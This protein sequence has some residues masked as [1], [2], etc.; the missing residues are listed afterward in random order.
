MLPVHP[1]L[2]LEASRTRAKSAIAREAAE[3][4]D[5]DESTSGQGSVD[6]SSQ[7]N[8]ESTPS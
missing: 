3:S 6:A 7:D 5:K 1:R 8:K 4:A 2:Y